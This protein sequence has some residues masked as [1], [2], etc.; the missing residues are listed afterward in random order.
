MRSTCKRIGRMRKIDTTT[1]DTTVTHSF[2]CSHDTHTI[3]SLI[4]YLL[5]LFCVMGI[6]VRVSVRVRLRVCGICRYE[7][8]TRSRVA[9]NNNNREQQ[10][11][12][13]HCQCCQYLP[14]TNNSNEIY[15]PFSSSSFSFFFFQFFEI[16]SKQINFVFFFL[17]L[18]GR[19]SYENW[20]NRGSYTGNY[21][22]HQNYYII[23]KKRARREEK[24]KCSKI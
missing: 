10:Q 3:H 7:K 8:V 6:V 11:C 14:G 22:Y 12:L 5:L 15:L 19:I 16:N 2:T 9:N 4:A 17:R 23:Y 24:K 13:L 20:I 1:Y 21:N 18:Q